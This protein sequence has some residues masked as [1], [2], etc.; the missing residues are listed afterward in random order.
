MTSVQITSLNIGL[1]QLLNGVSQLETPDLEQFVGQ[2]NSLLAQRKVPSL[3]HREMELLEL[4]NQGLP[5]PIQSRYDELQIKL[6]HE[7]I[8]PDE[9]QEL[10]SLIDTVEQATVDRLGSLIELSQIRRISLD[11]LMTQLGI[12]HSPVY[13]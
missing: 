3:S 5:E 2:I 8:A 1:D 11:E 7:T 12:H 10:L 9:H 4:I 13:A 6:H